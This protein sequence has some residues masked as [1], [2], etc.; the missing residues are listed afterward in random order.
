MAT[1]LSTAQGLHQL[2]HFLCNT[3]PLYSSDRSLD[4]RREKK[5][6]KLEYI[7][8]NSISESLIYL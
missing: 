3:Q 1:K 5:D 4:K 7:D 2:Q 8:E 6:V